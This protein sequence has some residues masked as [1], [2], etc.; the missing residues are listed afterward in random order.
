M[1]KM[2]VK[3]FFLKIHFLNYYDNNFKKILK[4]KNNLMSL[5]QKMI[6]DFLLNGYIS[7]ISYIKTKNRNHPK[8]TII[9]G[10]FLNWRASEDK[11]FLIIK[12]DGLS[13]ISIPFCDIYKIEYKNK[14]G[15]KY[16]WEDEKEV[17]ND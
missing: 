3:V 11:E 12:I 9:S 2:R 1:M 13:D 15:I 10:V 16:M 6:M 4:F 5:K 7:Y 14:Y 17:K 8:P